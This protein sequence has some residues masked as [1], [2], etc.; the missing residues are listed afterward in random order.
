MP[1]QAHLIIH[2]TIEKTIK[3][4][5]IIAAMTGHLYVDVSFE[6]GARAVGKMLK[7]RDDQLAICSFHT[8]VP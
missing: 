7:G 4:A 2:Q 3:P 6:Y 8:I 1:Q 5:T